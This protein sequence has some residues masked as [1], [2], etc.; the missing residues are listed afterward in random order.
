ME[1]AYLEIFNKNYL[2]NSSVKFREDLNTEK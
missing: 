2:A 1:V